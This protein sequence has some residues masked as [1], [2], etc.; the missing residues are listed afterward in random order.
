RFVK[1]SRI[2]GPEAEPTR[3]AWA[4]GALSTEQAVVI[5]GAIDKLPDWFGYTECIDA[6]QTLMEYAE[7]LNFDD[8]RRLANRIVEV[9]DPDGADEI[10]ARQ[11]A[12]QEK[13]AFD[14]TRL[15]F[16]NRGNAMSRVIWDASTADVHR[17][18]TVINAMTAPRRWKQLDDQMGHS[19]E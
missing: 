6:Q 18:Q 16:I 2:F 8:L 12:N 3:Q 14:Q 5:A 9:I 15:R 4:S 19:L 1:A 7:Q 17:L 10:L 13:M 11:L